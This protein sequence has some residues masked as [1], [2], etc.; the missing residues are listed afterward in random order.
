MEFPVLYHMGKKQ[1]MYQWRVW[2]EG[3]DILTEYGQVDGEKQI[4]SKRTA[5]K[6]IGKKNETSPSDQAL[7]EAAAMHK[8]KLTRKYSLDTEEAKKP[9]FLPM[10]AAKFEDKKAKLEYPVWVQPKLN[11]VRCLAYWD[12]GEVKTIS[13]SGRPYNLPHLAKDISNFLPK[14]YVL[15]GEVF[16][17]GLTL[18]QINRLVKKWRE[19]PTESTGGLRSS[20]LELWAYDVFQKGVE[21]PWSVRMENLKKFICASEPQS[22]GPGLYWYHQDNVIHVTSVKANSEAEVYKYQA[23][24]LANGFEGAIVRTDDLMYELGHRSNKLLKVKKFLDAEYEVTGYCDGRGKFKGCVIWICKTEEGKTFECTPRGTLEQKKAWFQA[25]AAY[26][27]RML[28][29]KFSEFSE[30][31]LPVPPVGMGFRLEEDM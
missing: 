21:E 17:R 29:V 4:A 7:K 18:Q 6:N 23:I 9:V 31:G 2:T 8:F 14:D 26:V 19:K 11:G 1:A 24:Y 25:G 12:D 22:K 16:V 30:S 13:R 20:D 5:G 3:P 10:L 28:T 27:G 15:D